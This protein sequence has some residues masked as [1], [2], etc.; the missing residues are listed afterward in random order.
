MDCPGCA[1]CNNSWLVGFPGRYRL[2]LLAGLVTVLSS[3]APGFDVA[4]AQEQD[5]FQKGINAFAKG[6]YQTA[7]NIWLVE[8]YEGSLDAQFNLGVLYLEGKGVAQKREDALFW[9]TQAAKGGHVEAQ[10]NLGHLYFENQD[11]PES[12]SQGMAWWRSASLQGFPIAQYN[13][14]RAL[15]Y[16]IGAPQDLQKSRYWMERSAS[17]GADIALRFLHANSEV[18]AEISA[19]EDAAV[20]AHFSKSEKAVEPVLSSIEPEQDKIASVPIVASVEPQQQDKLTGSSSD[21]LA[22]VQAKAGFHQYFVVTGENR[23]A[24]FT[25]SSRQSPVL[26]QA[27]PGLLLRGGSEQSGLIEVQVP[28]GFPGWISEAL[29]QETAALWKFPPMTPRLSQTRPRNRSK[30]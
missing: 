13:Y 18:F 29:L 7:A 21:K 19:A 3:L 26:I 27:P 9:F 10:Y 30:W 12:L 17:V 5:Q 23:P 16:G 8:A 15:F 20:V 1:G 22:T 25:G 6:D 2:W 11:D 24:V 14:G 4:Y 28:G